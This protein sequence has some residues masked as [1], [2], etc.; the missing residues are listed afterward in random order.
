ME[1]TMPGIM[2]NTFM[3]RNNDDD[4]EIKTLGDF[5]KAKRTDRKLSV[6]GLAKAAEVNS[7][8]IKDAED[9]YLHTMSKADLDTIATVLELT[10][11]ERHEMYDLSA[12]GKIPADI[13]EFVRN[14]KDVQL[15]LRTM[16]DGYP[17]KKELCRRFVKN[18]PKMSNI[19]A[20][21]VL[22]ANSSK[23]QN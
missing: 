19:K 3:N 9:G 22:G 5:I 10:P 12:G 7:T 18:I 8:Y 14:N 13:A 6:R 21:T 1:L 15:F 11:S 17:A 16:M 23:S 20:E 2:R 4:T